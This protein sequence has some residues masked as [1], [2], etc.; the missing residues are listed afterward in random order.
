MNMK[1]IVAAM[2]MSIILFTAVPVIAQT[3]TP[4]P[5]QDREG[6]IDQ[7]IDL[8]FGDTSDVD[9]SEVREQLENNPELLE[10]V[11]EFNNTLEGQPGMENSPEFNFWKNLFR[12]EADEQASIA[13]N[14]SDEDTDFIFEGE[15]DV[16]YDLADYGLAPY[17]DFALTNTYLNRLKASEKGRWAA[18]RLLYYEKLLISKGENVKPY[19]TTAW[20][21]FEN[22]SPDKLPDPYLQNCNDSHGSNSV[23]YTC[24]QSYKNKAGQTRPS[25]LQIGGYQM[26]SRKSEIPSMYQKCHGDRPLAEMLLQTYENSRYATKEHWDYT[27]RTAGTEFELE[28]FYGGNFPGGIQMVNRA[29]SADQQEQNIFSTSDIFGPGKNKNQALTILIGKDPCIVVGLNQYAVS[30]GDLINALKRPGKAYGYIGE[31]E[32]KALAAM[33]KALELFDEENIEALRE[34][35]EDIE[36]DDP[37]NDAS[38]G[39]DRFVHLCQCNPAYGGTGSATCNAGCGPT[40]FAAIMS[41]ISG[42]EYNPRDILLDLKDLGH[43]NNG[44]NTTLAALRSGYFQ[45]QGDGFTPVLQDLVSG[46]K[47]N[48]ERAR[49]F[50]T[51]KNKGRCFIIGSMKPRNPWVFPKWPNGISHIFAITDIRSDG[52]IVVH[53]SFLGCNPGSVT[54]KISHRVQDP[55]YV[56]NYAYALCSS[57]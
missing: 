20:L 43:W 39:D 16:S 17:F 51:G 52:K 23:N 10:E 21:W 32:K 6:I 9:T 38:Y 25:L 8:I 50:L 15:V 1:R 46:G 2:L 56:N 28:N 30:D 57:N 24:P 3:N 53:D 44:M 34:Q 13:G 14:L 19:L 4:I 37:G 18:T 7:I 33:V 29:V 42:K 35:R 12:N 11:N 5:E 49:P 48:I 54:E 31:P 26:Q 22:A 55:S 45:Q 36:T 41:S 47:L 40:T 27:R